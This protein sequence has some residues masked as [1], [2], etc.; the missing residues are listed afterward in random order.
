[1]SEIKAIHSK[2]VKAAVDQFCKTPADNDFDRRFTNWKLSSQFRK[3]FVHEGSDN[4]SLQTMISST[5]MTLFTHDPL[6]RVCGGR[7]RLPI[8][9]HKRISL[10][11]TWNRNLLTVEIGNRIIWFFSLLCWMWQKKFEGSEHI[12]SI[13]IFF[14]LRQ[15]TINQL[16]KL[17]WGTREKS[18]VIF[19]L[20][21]LCQP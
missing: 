11:K 13:H 16:T 14:T 5:C 17:L 12:E 19:H 4:L 10:H 7:K 2:G 20:F 6:W 8:W 3:S 1:M 9:K 15:T 21:F 18:L